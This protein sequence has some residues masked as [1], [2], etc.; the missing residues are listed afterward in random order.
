MQTRSGASN[1]YISSQLHLGLL[2]IKWNKLSNFMRN[3]SFESIWKFFTILLSEKNVFFI[4][5]CKNKM[6]KYYFPQYIVF[7]RKI[8]KQRLLWWI[9]SPNIFIWTAQFFEIY[10]IGALDV[11][12]EVQ[13]N[14]KNNHICIFL[15]H[16][17]E[18]LVS[19]QAY[20][21]QMQAL[22]VSISSHALK[23][24]L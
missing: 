19:S 10:G 13:Q 16:A 1:S 5:V 17:I 18:L 7:S 11:L 22:D 4:P 21:P 6:S 8:K 20:K 23:S 3:K 12:P 14:A 2:C 9:R 15:I 24:V